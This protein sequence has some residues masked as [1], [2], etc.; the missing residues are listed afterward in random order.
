MIKNR[1][2][3]F[4]LEIVIIKDVTDII[5]NTLSIAMLQN[6]GKNNYRTIFDYDLNFCDIMARAKSDRKN[7]L[8]IWLN[9]VMKY[10]TLPKSCPIK[11]VR[12]I[13]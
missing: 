9:N 7:L 4:D 13:E 1:N 8:N 6:K 3:S 2:E 5:W 10:G 11:S 12:Y